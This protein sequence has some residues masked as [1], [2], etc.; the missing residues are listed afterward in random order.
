[1]Q[2]DSSLTDPGKLHLQASPRWQGPI[3]RSLTVGNPRQS[4]LKDESADCLQR[5]VAV[6]ERPTRASD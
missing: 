5:P 6:L 4:D 2:S 1:M 3:L